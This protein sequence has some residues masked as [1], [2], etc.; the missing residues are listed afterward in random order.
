MLALRPHTPPLL[1]PPHEN[2]KPFLFIELLPRIWVFVQ[3][4]KSPGVSFLKD[5]FCCSL[6]LLWFNIPQNLSPIL[7]N[8]PRSTKYPRAM[9]IAQC[10]NEI[11]GFS[12]SHRRWTARD[13]IQG[14]DGDCGLGEMDVFH[15]QL[16]K[17]D[18]TENIII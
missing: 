1:L 15:L 9:L 6:F 13:W 3:R 2:M 11:I 7:Y 18:K 14:L 5:N 16:R 17:Q 8:T 12:P 10:F 4:K